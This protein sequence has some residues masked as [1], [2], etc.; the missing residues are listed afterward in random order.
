MF[1][2][3]IVSSADGPTPMLE[4]EPDDAVL[5]HVVDCYAVERGRSTERSLNS[6]L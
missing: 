6:K 1:S 2:M 3:I 5:R 4:I